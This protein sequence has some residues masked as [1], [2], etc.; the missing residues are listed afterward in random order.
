MAP[1]RRR[2]LKDP[3]GSEWQKSSIEIL[4]N[5]T[6]QRGERFLAGRTW[7]EAKLELDPYKQTW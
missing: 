7:V 3:L 2:L 4:R 5:H 1:R 6:T